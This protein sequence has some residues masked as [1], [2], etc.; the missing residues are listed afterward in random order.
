VIVVDSSIALQWLL[1]EADAVLAESLLGNPDLVAPDILLIEAA[2]VLAKKVRGSDATLD[3]AVSAP[4]LIRDI[5]SRFVSSADLA[6][7]A[8][9]L[10]VELVHPVYDCCFLACAHQVGGRLAT[11]D[12]P[13]VERL[14]ARGYGKDLHAWGD[15]A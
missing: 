8:L 11:R 13:F 3:D 9:R 12:Q 15:A 1:P 6:A 2:N 5:V 14:T 7:D 4:G 10:S